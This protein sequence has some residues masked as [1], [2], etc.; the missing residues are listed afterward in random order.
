MTP[1]EFENQFQLGISLAGQ[2]FQDGLKDLTGDT[3]WLATPGRAVTRLRVLLGNLLYATLSHM[4]PKWSATLDYDRDEPSALI[5]SAG[6]QPAIVIELR[7]S[8]E[9]LRITMPNGRTRHFVLKEGGA[10]IVAALAEICADYF[11][12]RSATRETPQA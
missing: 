5:L 6:N 8:Q 4:D 12:L 1:T 3:S 11:L 10:P 2:R 7:M 9:L